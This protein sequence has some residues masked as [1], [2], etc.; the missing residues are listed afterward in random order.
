L[1][2]FV[3]DLGL[4]TG[5]S[6]SYNILV[7]ASLTEDGLINASAATTLT[8]FKYL[9]VTF[10]DNGTGASLPEKIYVL[11]SIT[12]TYHNNL[13]KVTLNNNVVSVND[14]QDV[15]ISGNT[16]AVVGNTSRSESFVVF[17]DTDISG[18]G[19]NIEL[20]SKWNDTNNVFNV[21]GRYSSIV[22]DPTGSSIQTAINTNVTSVQSTITPVTNT[23]DYETTQSGLID[24]T[25]AA[26]KDDGSL[27]PRDSTSITISQHDTEE[28]NYPDAK[29]FSEMVADGLNTTIVSIHIVFS[30][31]D[32]INT[33]LT[34]IYPDTIEIGYTNTS[35]VVTQPVVVNKQNNRLVYTLD[36]SDSSLSTNTIKSIQY[37]IDSNHDF[38]VIL[39]TTQ[40]NVT[41]LY[42]MIGKIPLRN[43]YRP[44]TPTGSTSETEGIGEIDLLTNFESQTNVSGTVSA[45]VIPRLS[46]LLY[47][48]DDSENAT[49]SHMLQLNV[50][51]ESD[52]VKLLSGFLKNVINDID[53]DGT[54]ISANTVD[55]F[56]DTGAATFTIGLPTP[57]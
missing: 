27:N 47:T 18:T 9:Q 31:S 30:A 20:S 51:D 52:I 46:A 53:N 33:D 34:H 28:M 42:T 1:Q 48:Q 55:F 2:D 49:F 14:A 37:D 38:A 44:F 10:T 7:K 3:N 54:T 6:P 15:T 32:T 35:D 12:A 5:E 17:S 45:Y 41:T 56:T 21:T 43:E 19:V 23:Y 22:I 26:L 50:T 40:N 39:E 16:Y 25:T 13:Y 4:T 57:P 24:A 8:N 11:L 36:T 29:A